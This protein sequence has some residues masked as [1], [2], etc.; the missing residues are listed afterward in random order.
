VKD[1][2]SIHLSLAAAFIIL[3]AAGTYLLLPHRHGRSTP[4]R[5]HGAGALLAGLAVL[6]LLPQLTPPGP[7]LSSLFFYA[8]ALAAVVGGF[9]TVTSRNPV[10]SALWFASVVLSTTGLFL[11]AEAQFLA[12][13][14]IVVYA[15]AIIVTFLFVIML[16]QSTGL[17]TYDRTSRSP[18]GATLTSFALMFALFYALLVVKA[19]P[20]RADAAVQQGTWES[21][22]ANVLAVR[23]RALRPTAL[24]PAPRNP[25]PNGAPPAP[26]VAGLG[27]TLFTDHLISVE[28][29]GILLFVA[30][31]GALVIA[32]PK[33]PIRPGDRTLATPIIPTI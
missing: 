17:A 25:P 11:L 30:L 28:V 19:N 24:L 7:F 32:A 16:A 14:T 23:D 31:V 22:P 6:L 26:H 29:A 12:V 3:G 27:G 2:D 33:P 15:G 21:T 18:F 10:Y 5:I 4:R 20:S 8:F 1:P 13:G 9:L